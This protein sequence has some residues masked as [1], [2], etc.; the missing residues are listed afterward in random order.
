VRGVDRVHIEAS[1]QADHGV[2]VRC[3]LSGP[4]GDAATRRPRRGCPRTPP[5]IRCV[6]ASHGV[7][8]ATTATWT[9]DTTPTSR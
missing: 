2:G 8:P 7:C 9:S 5:S 4:T 3:D 6:I 1:Q